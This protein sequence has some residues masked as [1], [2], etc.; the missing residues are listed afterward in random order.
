MTS[1]EM[2][3]EQGMALSSSPIGRHA[4]ETGTNLAELAVASVTWDAEFTEIALRPEDLKFCAGGLFYRGEI[5]RAND[6]ARS[7][8]FERVDA[9]KWYL[10]KHNLGFQAAALSEHAN[11]GDF[12]GRPNAVVRNGEL[13]TI[14]DGDLT[15]LSISDVIRGVQEG[16]GEESNTLVVVKIGHTSGCLDVELVSQAKAILVRQG[17]VVQ[18][19]IHVVHNRF[20][21]RATLVESFIYRLVCTNGMT[22]RECVSRDGIVRTRKL[23][24]EEF[25]NAR[26]LQLDQIRRLTQRNWTGLQAQLE[27]LKSTSDREAHVEELLA[28]WL[29]RGRISALAMMPRLLAA[30]REEGAENTHY[31]AVNA[32]TRVATHDQELSERQRRVLGSLAG[33]LAFSEVHIC[34]RCFTVLGRDAADAV[35]Q[36]GTPPGRVESS[37]LTAATA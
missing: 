22:R 8:L 37:L 33:L 15:T 27:A 34:P 19:G 11:L 14:S 36:H 7:R 1:S 30:W 16:L 10:A 21:N 3:T 12:G 35:A 29:Q 13:F 4:F 32:L 31:G 23:S 5:L 24:V 25:P 6:D 9:P 2:K 20:G 26:E 18:S 28:R 17:D